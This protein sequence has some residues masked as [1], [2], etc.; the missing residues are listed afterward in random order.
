MSAP[1]QEEVLENTTGK[2]PAS[3]R[4]ALDGGQTRT[5]P[6]RFERSPLVRSA[7]A[8]ARPRQSHDLRDIT[9]GQRTAAALRRDSRVRRTLAIAD[10]AAA[11]LAL[12]AVVVVRGKHPEPAALL[13][14]PLVAIFCK[15]ARLYDRDEHV[16]R[17]STLDQAPQLLQVT[18]LLTLLA[19]FAGGALVRGGL[20]RPDV[21]ILWI[22][23]AVAI[24]CLR[25][26]ARR[27]AARTTTPERVLFIGSA[28]DARR[29][30]SRIASAHSLR[31]EMVGRVRVERG[32]H[33]DP[34][35]IGSLEDLDYL[36]RAHAVERV[37][38]A[39]EEGDSDDVLETIR[40][41]KAL[42]V[43]VS[44]LPRLF[45][46]VG[47]SME[48]DDVDGITVL[49]LR[50]Y[51][52]SRTSWYVKRAFD[53]VATSA[54]LVLVAPLLGAIAVAIRASSPGPILFR[55]PRVGRGGEPFEMLKFRTMYDGADDDKSA[56]R[57]R[58]EAQGF[59]KI[60][61]DPRVTPIGRWLRRTSLDELPQLVNVLRGEMS[62]VG[63]RPLVEEEDRKIAGWHHRRREGTPGMTGV[64]QVL[65]PTRVSLEEM[66]KLD[67]LYRANWSL[68]LD[69]KI[70]LRTL[71][72]VSA[73][74]GC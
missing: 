7:I 20:D 69:L 74:R 42:G 39:P 48:F 29:V 35:P 72:H 24:V 14:P 58:N 65:G 13:M 52:L 11:A 30:Q 17:K 1:L 9:E 22:V 71:A 64:W 18:T 47:S 44:V 55:Q 51:G 54:G 66:V 3:A 41:V 19:W 2:D 27:V 59:F 50:R 36:L 12:G 26:L 68:W 40:L 56:L 21:A 6:R 57:E 33:A 4:S 23:L 16:L 5:P 45:E 63:P 73:R 10:F 38:I 60:A 31:A 25:Y 46:V 37:M 61:D 28:D 70:L 53:L 43:K 34:E 32:D 8:P 15:L 67:Y 62:L 49:G